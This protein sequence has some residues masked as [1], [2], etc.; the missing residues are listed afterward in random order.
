MPKQII[1]TKQELEHYAEKMPEINPS[2]I[3]AMLTVK[4]AANEIQ[5]EILDILQKKYQLSEGKLRVMIILHQQKNSISPSSLAQKT[6][7]TKATISI[8]LKRMQRDGLVELISSSE[9][10]RAKKIRLSPKGRAMMDKI[11]PDHYL[12]V[13]RLMGKLNSEEQ[14][15]LIYLLQKIASK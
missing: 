10:G 6:G 3:I 13:S 5:H 9:D 8:M 14:Q 7:V 4:Q 2:S 15:Q 12:R 1:P 11:L